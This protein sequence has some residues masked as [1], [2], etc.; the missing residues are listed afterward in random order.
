MITS[1][2][3][4]LAMLITLAFAAPARAIQQGLSLQGRQYSEHRK[5]Q[6]RPFDDG[7]F[8]YGAAYELRDA[9]GFWQLG[10]RYTP[11]AGPDNRYDYIVTPFL[12]LVFRDQIFLGGIGIQK[13]YLPKT[14]TTDDEWTDLYYNVILGLGIPL[15]RRLELQAL[16]FYDFNH[17]GKMIGDFDFDDVEFGVSLSVLF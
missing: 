11:N 14:D 4:A 10:A 15:G 7:D 13:D 17:V 2:R 9:M 1:C 8:A 5:F 3:I 12:N 6:R 16:A